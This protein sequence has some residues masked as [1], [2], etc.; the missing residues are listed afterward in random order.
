VNFG[1]MGLTDSVTTF[2]WLMLEEYK[3]RHED[4]EKYYGAE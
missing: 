1:T 3:K 2:N 4:D